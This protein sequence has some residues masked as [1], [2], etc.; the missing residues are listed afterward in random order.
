MTT[1]YQI[2]ANGKIYTVVDDFASVYRALITGAVSDEVL[3]EL[4]APDFEV[5]IDRADLISKTTAHGLYAVTG[6]SEKSFPN[7]SATAY[8]VDLVLAASGFRD[9]PLTVTI[10]KNAS[11][12]VNAPAAALRRLPVRIQGRVVTD[13]AQRWPIAGAPVISVD[14]PSAPPPPQHTVALR[15]PLYMAHPAGATVR[16]IAMAGFG[17]ATLAEDAAAGSRMLNLSDRAGLVVNSILRFSNGTETLVEYGIVDSLGPGAGAGQVFLRQ[18]LNRSYFS[19]AATTVQFLNPGAAGTTGTLQTDADAGD[20]V[21]IASQLLIGNTVEVDPGTA[22]TEYHEI[23]A[24][25]GTDGYYSLDGVC[26]VGEIFLEASHATFTSLTEDW[27]VQYD[28]AVN[29]VDFRLHT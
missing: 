7:L 8:T 3:G 19:G 16:E 21:L 9:Q 13:T 15:S 10:P 22:A 23:G 2:A 17:S 27:S 5:R 20:G 6:Y 26:R 11:F 28:K 4:A 18:S 14:D 24:L 1:A 25:T 12:P 29:V